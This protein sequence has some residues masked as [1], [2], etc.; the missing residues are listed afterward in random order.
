MGRPARDPQAQSAALQMLARGWATAGEVA[1]MAGVSVQLVRSWAKS[2]GIDWHKHRH[3][4][5]TGTWRRL[6]LGEQ[7]PTKKAKLRSLANSAKAQWRSM[8]YS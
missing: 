4:H 7:A 1:R 8:E 2:A 6:V 5:L 3:N